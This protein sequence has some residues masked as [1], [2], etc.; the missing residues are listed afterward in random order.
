MDSKWKFDRNIKEG[1][2][3]LRTPSSERNGMFALVGFM[4]FLTAGLDF[5]H[6]ALRGLGILWIVDTLITAMFITIVLIITWVIV[7]AYLG[8]KKDENKS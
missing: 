7:T 4:V 8:V 6:G 5:V 1:L 3:G 2:T